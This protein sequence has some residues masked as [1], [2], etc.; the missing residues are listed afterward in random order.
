[1]NPLSKRLR[2]V[3]GNLLGKSHWS[4]RVGYRWF[5]SNLS[6]PPVFPTCPFEIL[7][8]PTRNYLTWARTQ[9]RL[10]VTLNP[11]KSIKQ[12]YDKQSYYWSTDILVK[13]QW[14]LS[15]IRVNGKYADSRPQVSQERQGRA[16]RIREYKGSKAL[17]KR[18]SLGPSWGLGGTLKWRQ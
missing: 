13:K 16:R 3:L 15:Q 14:R 5:H 1:M 2:P 8:G 9:R 11:T 17:L 12:Q 7:R 10:D 18:K 4:V 6:W